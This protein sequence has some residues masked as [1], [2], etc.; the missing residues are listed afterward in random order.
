MNMSPD[1]SNKETEPEGE[2]QGMS[3]EEARRVAG[4][5]KGAGVNPPESLRSIIESEK[6]LD[7]K[8]DERLS[9]LYE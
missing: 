5:F 3:E 2:G 9:D 1:R 6:E 8:R 4:R 7:A